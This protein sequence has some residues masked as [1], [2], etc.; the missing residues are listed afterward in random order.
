MRFIEVLRARLAEL[1]NTRAERIAEMEAVTAAATEE[2]RSALTEPEEAQFNALRDQVAEI[3]TEIAATEARIGELDEIEQRQRAAS[4]APTTPTPGSSTAT[5]VLNDRS[6]TPVAVMDAITRSLEP[7]VEDPDNMAHARSILQRHLNPLGGEVGP[8]TRQWGRNLIARMEPVYARAFAK[9]LVG[10][11]TLLSDEERTALSVGSNTNGGFLLPTHLD[12]TIIL[13]NA[14]TSN[15]IRG[16]SRVVTLTEGETWNGVTS[17]GITASWDGELAEVSD[18]S[19]TFARKSV[20]VNIAQTFAQAS[21]AATEDIAGLSSDLLM[22]FADARD[23]LEGAAHATGSGNSNQPRGIFTALDANTNVEIITTTANTTGVVDLQSVYRQL[24]IRWRNRSTWVMNPLFSL[25]IQALGS[26]LGVAFSR[27][28]TQP[29]TDRILGRPVVE[30]DDAP[31]AQTTNANDL[32]AVLGDFQNYLIV[33][34][35][36][37]MAVEYIPHMFNTAN[38]LPDGRRGWYCYW[39]TGADSLNDVAFRILEEKT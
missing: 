16:I 29:T 39:R 10:G 13:T 12:P 31:S 34:K 2:S 33:D 5:D 11:A 25:A 6:A 15:A 30:S 23:R 35:P 24:P 7:R 21:I 20:S 32:V 37:G 18:D 27:D 28:I 22:L 19:P 14:G 1:T 26:S 38:N 9:Y 36:G 3:D 4:I 17:A 8:E